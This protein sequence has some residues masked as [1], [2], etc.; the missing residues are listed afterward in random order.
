MND[1]WVVDT[2]FEGFNVLGEFEG[3]CVDCEEYACRVSRS[4]GGRYEVRH[5]VGGVTA[6]FCIWRRGFEWE[7]I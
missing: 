3:S 7:V 1:F 4:T 2:S 6:V 5:L